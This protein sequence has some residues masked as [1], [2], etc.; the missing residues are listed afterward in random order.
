VLSGV[1]PTGKLHLGNYMGAI[2]NWV[3]LQ[4]DYGAQRVAG[5]DAGAARG[6][7][8]RPDRGA[9]GG[10][11]ASPS[12]SRPWQGAWARPHPRPTRCRG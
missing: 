3:P 11:A 7:V 2:K 1:Q 10:G 4:D 6:G 5:R 8:R 12:H 9:N